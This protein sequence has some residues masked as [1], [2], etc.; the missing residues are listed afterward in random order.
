MTK[1]ECRRHGF[2]EAGWMAGVSISDDVYPKLDRSV[3]PAYESSCTILHPLST[4][5]TISSSSF[6]HLDAFRWGRVE[7]TRGSGLN[8]SSVLK[9]MVVR[10]H[11]INP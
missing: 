5:S 7:N 11:Q 10:F 4:V 1:M 2:R 3:V 9:R 8:W 6:S